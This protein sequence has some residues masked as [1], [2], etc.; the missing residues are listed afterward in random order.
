[1]PTE[2]NSQ[3]AGASRSDGPEALAQQVRDRLQQALQP[4]AVEINDES[5]LHIGHGAPGAHFR[6][7]VV[8]ACF[9]GVAPVQR[10]RMVQHALRGLYPG[11][12]HALRMHTLAPGE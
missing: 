4:Q 12:I 8:A 1:M 9:G 11:A 7:R 3:P 6:I 2:T 10:H 5:H